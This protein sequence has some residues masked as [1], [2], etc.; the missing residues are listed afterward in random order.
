MSIEIGAEL[1]KSFF[2]NVFHE[3]GSGTTRVSEVPKRGFRSTFPDPFITMRKQSLETTVQVSDFGVQ[4][5]HGDNSAQVQVVAIVFQPESVAALHFGDEFAPAFDQSCA[6]GTNDVFGVAVVA[7]IGGH[8]FVSHSAC[9]PG[10][11]SIAR[12]CWG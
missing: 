3:S 9:G 10:A 7:E 4:A 12:R 2:F 6:P 1:V 5:Q 8:L 11:R